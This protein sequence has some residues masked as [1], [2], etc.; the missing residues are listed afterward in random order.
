MLAFACDEIVMH[1]SL[2][3]GDC[4]PIMYRRDGGIDALPPTERAKAE[5]PVL[6]DFLD[7]AQRK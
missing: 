7:S 3:D 2:G 1:A 4:A 6:A 5:S